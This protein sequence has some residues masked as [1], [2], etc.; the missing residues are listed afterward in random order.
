MAMKTLDEEIR[1]ALTAQ[2]RT[3]PEGYFD[4]L[5]ARVF[6]RIEAELPQDRL[7]VEAMGPDMSTDNTKPGSA[8]PPPGAIGDGEER[9]E[10]SG[11]HDIKAMAK[12]TK[13]RIS[14][15]VSTQ[16]DVEESL[17]ASASSQSL[18]AIVLPEP[19]H[20]EPSYETDETGETDEDRAAV[21]ASAVSARATASATARAPEARGGLPVWVYGAVGV[22]AVAAVVFFVMRG[23][24]KKTE[25]AQNTAPVAADPSDLNAPPAPPVVQPGAVPSDDDKADPTGV[26]SETGDGVATAPIEAADGDPAATVE[27]SADPAPEP[28][29]DGDRPAR[30]R[31]ASAKSTSA[32][33]SS[34]TSSSSSTGSASK[35]AAPKPRPATKP[36]KTDDSKRS[37]EDLL[38]EASGGAVSNKDLEAAAP[39]VED[40]KPAKTDLSRAEIQTG[41]KKILG[42]VSACYDKYKEPGTVMI[43]VA[44]ETSG[45]V[46]SA[47]ATGKFKN[48]E[49]GLCVSEAVKRA[50]FESWEG[51]AKRF[52]YPFLLSD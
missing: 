28:E 24:G 19:G 33:S 5:S 38:D 6:Q 12:T 37:L 42:R 18:S 48:T 8:A 14:R 13:Q 51:K 45:A 25:V 44:I 27:A 16:S 39:K 17:L 4:T 35:P 22:V 7:E 10:H 40:E 34:S 46:A 26:G 50:T 31:S 9:E 32:P 2:E 41:M 15:R 20:D 52:N 29:R 23:G 36:A 49:T 11:L 43:S 1:K 30:T 3:V 47:D 21:G